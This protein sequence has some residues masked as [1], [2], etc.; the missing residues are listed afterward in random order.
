MALRQ[1]LVGK[2]GCSE[3]PLT[4]IQGDS[5]TQ[6]IQMIVQRYYGGVDLG[7]LTWDVTFENGERKTDTHYLTDIKVGEVN[8]SCNWKP[9]GLATI[10]EGMTKFQ[11]EGYAEDKNGGAAMVWQSGVY[12]FNV[13]ADM[14]HVTSDAEKEALTEVQ[15]LILYVNNELPGGVQAGSDAAQ[16]AIAANKAADDANAAT[17]KAIPA[18]QAADTAATNAQTAAVAANQAAELANRA[19][20]NANSLGLIDG[21]LCMEVE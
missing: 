4:L 5:N 13:S 14:N 16:A 11:L 1:I 17:A 20:D 18:V 21:K 7:K 8:I 12:Y 15:R 3:A 9:H 6:I 2:A 10:A 19:A